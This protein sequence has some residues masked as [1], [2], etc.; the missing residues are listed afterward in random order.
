MYIVCGIEEETQHHLFFSCLVAIKLTIKCGCRHLIL[1]T[2]HLI[3]FGWRCHNLDLASSI[4]LIYYWWRLW[5]S[6]NKVI[7]EH[8]QL[9]IDFLARQF[10]FPSL[11]NYV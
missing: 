1:G 3:A 11:N 6:R 10:T 5:K 4:K 2:E 9:S 7:F 8:L